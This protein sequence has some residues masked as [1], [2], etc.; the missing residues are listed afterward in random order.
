MKATATEER[1]NRNQLQMQ[2]GI[3]IALD[4]HQ[5]TSHVWARCSDVFIR[6]SPYSGIAWRQNH[7]IAL[8]LISD[9][10]LRHRI[11]RQN[12]LSAA[13]PVNGS[14]S[15]ELHILVGR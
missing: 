6:N 10:G 11:F 7:P 9:S 8:V 15:L 1:A 3:C 13:S 4:I 12:T 14:L 5:L 2:K